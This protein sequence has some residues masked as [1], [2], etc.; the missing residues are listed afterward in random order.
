MKKSKM[1]AFA[2]SAAIMVMGAGYAA[3]TETVTINNTVETGNLDVDTQTPTVTVYSK[4]GVVD[5]S[6]AAK[7]TSL[8]NPANGDSSATVTLG[9]LYP[10]AIVNVTV[11]VKN[12]G[13]IPVK[14]DNEATVEAVQADTNFEVKDIVADTSEVAVNG[15]ANITYTIAVKDG[16]EENAGPTTFTLSPV[17]EQFNQ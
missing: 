7:S 17:Y 5:A 6:I 3:W 12:V 11:P 16:A 14:L 13:S 15:S 4:T 10:G 8:S 2:L 9:N 1:L